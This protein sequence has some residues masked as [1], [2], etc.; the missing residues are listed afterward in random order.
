MIIDEKE[1]L[2]EQF[3]TQFKTHPIFHRAKLTVGTKKELRERL[4]NFVIS[5]VNYEPVIAGGIVTF[6][7][8]Y[9]RWVNG[10]LII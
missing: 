6:N 5:Y 1:E 9:K 8:S 4:S 3:S 7:F 10:M 2:L